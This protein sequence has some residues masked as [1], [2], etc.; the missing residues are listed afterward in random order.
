MELQTLILKGKVQLIQFVITKW[1]KIPFLRINKS[2]VAF[3]PKI[4]IVPENYF[5]K[6]TGKMLQNLNFCSRALL[7]IYDIFEVSA[8]KIVN[9]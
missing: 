9:L 8:C 1:N 5:C 6:S 3:G 7:E 2:G 4:R